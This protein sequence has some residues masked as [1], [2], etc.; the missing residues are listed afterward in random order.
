MTSTSLRGAVRYR[1]G[2]AWFAALGTAWVFVLVLLGA[3]TTTIGAGMAF[4]DWPLSNGSIN[5]E[6]WL[7]NIAMFA[8]HSHRLSGTVMGLITVVLAV[9][10]QRVDPR[11]WLRRLGWAAVALVVVQGV[12]GGQRVRL[13]AWQIAGLQM[14]VGQLLRIP[15]GIAA[16]IF[17]IV[18]LAIAA[19]VS[20]PWIEAPAASFAVSSA[21]R[22]LG[23][24]CTSLMLIQLMI[25]ATMRHMQAGLAIPTFPLAPGGSIVPGA[26]DAAVAIHFAHRVLAAA[27]AV[28]AWA[29]AV[30]VWRERPSSL[31]TTT[32]LVMTS[33]V[34]FQIVLGGAVIWTL[35][36]PCYTTAHVVIGACALASSFLLT[37]V[38]FRNSLER[39]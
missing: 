23:I 27:I 35:R 9:W 13:D 29:Y 32:A 22:R 19:A 4:P 11:R 17:V 14:S 2:L 33:L 21:V 39:R 25:A 3:F 36:H 12:I 28:G 1:P 20:R 37:W 10:L 31:L 16:Q 26:W 5:P 38:S 6:G 8:E 24:I 18:L 30:A 7:S 34:S 15:H